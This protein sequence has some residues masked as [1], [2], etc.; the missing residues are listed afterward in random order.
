[1]RKK[2][3]RAVDQ[4]ISNFTAGLDY[5][6]NDSDVNNVSKRLFGNDRT[7]EFAAD[8]SGLNSGLL[9]ASASD[10]CVECRA[11]VILNSKQLFD[12]GLEK[13]LKNN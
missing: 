13:N 9:R 8:N 4:K 6:N 2:D 3:A 11:I 10:K 12:I 7:F 1:M 5:Q